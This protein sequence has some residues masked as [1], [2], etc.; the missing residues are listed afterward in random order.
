MLYIKCHEAM[1]IIRN[2]KLQILLGFIL[3]CLCHSVTCKIVKVFFWATGWR[4]YLHDAA[5]ASV[6]YP[7]LI[8]GH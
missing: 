6:N 7:I 8:I 1:A 2:L 4:L 5:A 3:F